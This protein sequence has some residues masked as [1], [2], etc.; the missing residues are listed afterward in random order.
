MERKEGESRRRVGRE[1]GRLWAVEEVANA[2]TG[3]QRWI[4]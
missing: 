2:T 1:D 3:L 4:W